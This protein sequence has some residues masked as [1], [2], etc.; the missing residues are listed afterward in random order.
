MK[1]RGFWPQ[2]YRPESNMLKN[3]PKMLPPKIY[4]LYACIM[5]LSCQ[6][7]DKIYEFNLQA[8]GYSRSSLPRGNTVQR[9]NKTND[10]KHN[11]QKTTYKHNA[12]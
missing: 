3:L 7:F 9:I 12:L 10:H 6:Q 1:V 11:L 5:L 2:I 8:V 4:L